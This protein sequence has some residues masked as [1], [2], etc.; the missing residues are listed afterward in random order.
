M[1]ELRRITL[2]WHPSYWATVLGAGMV[3]AGFAL[4][5]LAWRAVAALLLVPLQLPYAVSGGVAGLALIGL[6]AALLNAQASRH[7]AARE[8]LDVEAAVTEAGRLLA[9]SQQAPPRR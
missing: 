8:R 9:A 6:G 2:T 1:A 7:L 5:T 4:L 3:L